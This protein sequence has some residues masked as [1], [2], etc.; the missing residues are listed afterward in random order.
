MSNSEALSTFEFFQKFP[1]E[2]V[3][4]RFFEARRRGDEPICGHRGSVN[5]GE[6]K[7]HKPMACRC[8]EPLLHKSGQAA[9]IKSFS[10]QAKRSD[11]SAITECYAYSCNNAR[12]A[13]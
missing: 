9:D 3:A 4:R 13:G 10:S 7:D 8:R 2:D 1:S 6:R 12:L 5:A 11:S